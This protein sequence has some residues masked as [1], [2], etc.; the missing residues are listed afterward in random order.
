MSIRKSCIFD[1]AKNGWQSDGII[2][3]GVNLIKNNDFAALTEEPFTLANWGKNRQ[4]PIRIVHEFVDGL[5]VTSWTVTRIIFIKT[6]T[7]YNV[8]EE[9]I[10]KHNANKEN[11]FEW[12][13]EKKDYLCVSESSAG[14]DYDEKKFIK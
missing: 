12:L 7:G 3:L 2:N 8:C 1:H 14:W 9:I 13:W 5:L 4:F 10:E 6:D 11:I